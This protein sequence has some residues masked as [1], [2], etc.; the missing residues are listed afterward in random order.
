MRDPVSDLQALK[1]GD[2]QAWTQAFHTLWRFA[3]HAA[4]SP[5]AGLDPD[6]AEDVAMEAITKLVPRVGTVADLDELQALL[7]TIAHRQA[8]SRARRKSAAKRPQ[9]AVHLDALPEPEG[10]QLLDRGPP[11]CA[12]S[13]TDIA[14]LLALLHRAL[15]SVDATTR[16]LLMG[17]H[18]EGLR[19]RELS[20]KLGLPQGTVT[21]LMARGLQRIRQA[22]RQSPH[23]M[24]QLQVY[25]R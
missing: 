23:L 24:K 16:Q 3:Y 17:H 18:V 12:L 11:D 1:S 22:L 4:L 5:R 2:E 9:F 14:E 13:E 8:I 21:V 25:L 20:E 6:E 10:E 7:V 15:S 19:V